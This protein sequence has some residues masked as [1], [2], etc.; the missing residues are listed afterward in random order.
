MAPIQLSESIQRNH[1]QSSKT[2]MIIV[3]D[4]NNP[5][6]A[7]FGRQVLERIVELADRYNVVIV[8]DEVYEHLVFDQARHIPIATLPGARE[9]T[10]TISSAG[11]TFSTTG[12][13]I[14]WAIAPPEITSAILTVKQYLTYVNGAPFQPAI[15]TGLRLPDDFYA[16]TA[17]NLQGKRDLLVEALHDAGFRVFSPKGAYYVLV[18][19]A[20][21]GY[22]DA[23]ELSRKLP[24]TL[25]VAGVPATAFVQAARRGLPFVVA[26]HLL[27]A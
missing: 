2:R 24:S 8:I 5:T 6:G 1:V 25:G 18:D 26:I 9:R 23:T 4:P 14:G 22:P 16:G 13:K 3:N 19:T 10:V 17:Q 20:A 21:V 12:W 11:K 15:A 7:V 27:Q